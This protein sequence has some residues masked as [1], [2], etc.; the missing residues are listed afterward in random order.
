MTAAKTVL[1]LRTCKSDGTS[2]NG[3]VWPESGPV[4]CPDWKPTAECGNGLHGALWGEG[5]GNL[6]NWHL[7][8][9]W[10]VVK[11]KA[12]D[13]I[14]LAGKVKF[15]AG[16]VVYCGDRLGATTYLAA[17]GGEGRAVIGGTATAGYMG[18]ATA[19]YMGTAT[20]GD[21]GTA[22][23]GY[24]GTATAGYS[25]TATAGYSGTVQ[26]R[27]WDGNRYRITVGYIGED[28]LQSGV[29]Y[30][31]DSKGAIVVAQR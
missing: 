20:A 15:P 10:L 3:F 28:G 21:G 12:S 2:R 7:S 31:C 17:N 30:R 25:G 13:V 11:V 1:I 22:T 5:N 24:M 6:F 18:T 4:T 16:V 29:A 9:R 8:A 23:A 19:G 14:D 26:L 27:W